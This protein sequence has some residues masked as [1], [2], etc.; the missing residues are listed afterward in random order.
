MNNFT[1][2]KMIKKSYIVVITLVIMIGGFLLSQM[3]TSP[4]GQAEQTNLSA[5]Q[6]QEVKAMI[7]EL[8][9]NDP[10]LFKQAIIAFQQRE[11]QQEEQAREGAVKQLQQPLYNEASDPFKG[12]E[13]PAIKMVYFTDF[14]C[15]YCKRIEPSLAQLVE[16]FPQLQIKIKM[17]PLQG[18]SSVASVN[19]AQ[20]VWLNEPEKFAAVAKML[21]ASPRK[22]DT[23]TMSKV[24]KIT[25]TE[26]WLTKTDP[27]V[28]K[29][30]QNN[31]DLMRQL[32]LSGT[33]SLLFGDTV[34]PGLVPYEQIKQKLEYELAV[35]DRK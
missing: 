3:L 20:T 31:L 26:Q 35:L 21:M 19:F 30:V 8:V 34:I 7:K 27:K 22:L 5:E 16:E 4:T 13:T 10:E 15:P 32:G 29:M 23:A 11:Q 1:E 9:V 18:P 28:A 6:K 12:S 33:P 25:D 14:N 24:A 17:V 2:S